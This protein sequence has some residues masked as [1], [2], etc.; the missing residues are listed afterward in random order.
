[1]EHPNTHDMM[2]VVGKEE[3]VASVVVYPG[4]VGD[5]QRVV[6][7]ANRWKVPIFPISMGRNRRSHLSILD[8]L[9]ARLR[10]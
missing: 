6:G 7:W 10:D 2:N 8:R 5:V 1:M 9:I 3:L 4:D